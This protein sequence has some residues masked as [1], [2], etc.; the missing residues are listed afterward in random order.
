MNSWFQNG[1][2]EECHQDRCRESIVLGHFWRRVDETCNTIF[3]IESPKLQATMS[4]LPTKVLRTESV[5]QRASLQGLSSSVPQPS[6]VQSRLC[7]TV[8]RRFLLVQILDEALAIAED[9]NQVLNDSNVLAQDEDESQ[10]MRQR[11]NESS[12][13]SQ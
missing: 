2:T 13:Q 10:L 11:R 1:L 7:S 4:F 8:N 5:V 6:S 12:P 9:T 3:V